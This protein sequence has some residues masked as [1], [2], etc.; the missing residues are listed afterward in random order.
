M[1]INDPKIKI[2]LIAVI[3]VAL[4]YVLN[5]NMFSDQT[6]VK[7]NMDDDDVV[8]A[9]EQK[10]PEFNDSSVGDMVAEYD[11]QI[12][13]TNISSVQPTDNSGNLSVFNKTD[14]QGNYRAT[15]EGT[16]ELDSLIHSKEDVSYN[17]LAHGYDNLMPPNPRM[18]DDDV[19]NRFSSTDLSLAELRLDHDNLITTDRYTIGTNTV[20]ST[21]K[22]ANYDLRPRPPNP[23]ITISPWNNSSIEPDY[24]TRPL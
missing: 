1:I 19:K 23:K 16:K 12:R 9:P 6:Y 20:G 17:E 3:T 8:T 2:A 10:D 14:E 7:E 5:N 18:I 13:P 11:E 22:A 15:I 21:N 24:N 4:I